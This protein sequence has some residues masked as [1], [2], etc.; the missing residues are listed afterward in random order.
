MLSLELS[1]LPLLVVSSAVFIQVAFKTAFSVSATA[2]VVSYGG[3]Q[4]G[5]GLMGRDDFYIDSTEVVSSNY[6]TAGCFGSL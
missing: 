4:A 1:I 6:V 5:F 3:N 2:K